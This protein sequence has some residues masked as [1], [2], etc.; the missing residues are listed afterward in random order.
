MVIIF[1]TGSPL[2]S[3]TTPIPTNFTISNGRGTG[4]ADLWNVNGCV[5]DTTGSATVVASNNQYGAIT[6]TVKISLDSVTNAMSGTGKGSNTF[7]VPGIGSITVE[8]VFNV[9][10]D[11][12]Q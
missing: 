11:A 3:V 4:S 12:N 8:F 7:S 1:Q 2:N 9:T 6:F 5:T 10:R